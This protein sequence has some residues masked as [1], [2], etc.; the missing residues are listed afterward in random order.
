[1]NLTLTDFPLIRL[2]WGR[3]MM[4]EATTGTGGPFFHRGLS[5]RNLRGVRLAARPPP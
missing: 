4:Y 3:P 1:V 5:N 2:S